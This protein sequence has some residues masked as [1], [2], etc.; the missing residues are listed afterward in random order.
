MKIYYYITYVLSVILALPFVYAGSY[1]IYRR[2]FKTGFYE[3]SYDKNALAAIW[4]VSSDTAVLISQF[5]AVIFFLSL[6]FI[7]LSI[8]IRR[9]V[10]KDKITFIVLILFLILVI[11]LNQVPVILFK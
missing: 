11:I 6:L 10:D 9:W 2:I 4:N 3:D 8:I 5:F 7:L 1:T